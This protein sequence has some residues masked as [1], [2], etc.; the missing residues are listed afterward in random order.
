M[1]QVKSPQ[2]SAR[3]SESEKDEF[4]NYLKELQETNNVQ[5]GSVRDFISFISTQ[6]ITTTAETEITQIDDRPSIYVEDI[7]DHLNSFVNQNE[8]PL[9][10]TTLDVVKNALTK[11][12]TIVEVEKVI[13]VPAEVKPTNTQTNEH[14]FIFTDEQ[15]GLMT[16]INS[17]RNKKLTSKELQA[18]SFNDTVLNMLFNEG[19]I[20]NF[21]GNFYTGLG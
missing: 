5:F 13:E 15:E 18:E 9:E 8:V 17:N 3:V 1:Y 6:Q 19:T 4:N 14:T 11:E 12:P 21:G 2:I 20:Y 16:D 10:A 7:Q